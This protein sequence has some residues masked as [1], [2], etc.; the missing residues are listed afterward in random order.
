MHIGI[1]CCTSINFSGQPPR[2]IGGHDEQERAPLVVGGARRVRNMRARA[3]ARARARAAAAAEEEEEYEDEGEAL[4]NCGTP[5][6]IYYVNSLISIYYVP[7][8]TELG[9]TP[10]PQKFSLS[11]PLSLF[12]VTNLSAGF[13][14]QG[15]F[16]S[17]FCNGRTH[18]NKG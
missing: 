10:Q 16:V 9:K 13:Y 5:Q 15:P 18:T 12:L 2:G 14:S 6:C 1:S 8:N 17:H 7:Y 11:Q 3:A 4:W